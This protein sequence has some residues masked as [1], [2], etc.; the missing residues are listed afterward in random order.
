MPEA[1]ATFGTLDIRA[2]GFGCTGSSYLVGHETE[3]RLTREA[4]EG[5]GIPVITAAQAIRQTLRELGVSA[6][7]LVSPYTESLS[8]AG[9]RYWERAGFRITSKLRVDNTLANTHAIYELGSADALEAVRRLDKAGADCV[10]ISGTGMPTLRALQQLA[11]E[12]AV[13]VVSSN[14]CL[15]WVLCREVAPELAPP[16]PAGLMQ[17]R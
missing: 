3:D 7:A 10:V 11:G 8:A 14:L 16:T 5:C 6:F 17:V 1:I 2:F 13:P 4:Q 12:L 9:Y 15:A